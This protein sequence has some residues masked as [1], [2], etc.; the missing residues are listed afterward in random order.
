MDIEKEQ[1]AIARLKAFEPKEE[2]YYLCY[3]GGKDSD[4]IRI[5]AGLAGVRHEVHHNLTTV[6]APETVGYVKSFDYVMIDKAYYADGTHKTMWNLIQKK[7]LPPTRLM[8]YCCEQL[9]EHGGEG[10]MKITGVRWAES[11]SRKENGGFVK[12]IG[13]PKTTQK[14]LTENNV[15]FLLTARGGVVL[16]H[17][18]AET[19]R[20]VEYCYRTVSTM[21]NPIIDW[22]DDDV[23]EFLHHYG[24]ESNPL[25]QCGYK[26]IGCVGCPMASTTK[27]RYDFERHPAYKKNYIKAF[28]RM[29]EARKEAG[30]ETEWKSGY[31]VFKWWMGKDINQLSFFDDEL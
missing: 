26:R 18:N 5:L 22:S 4:C 29:L 24:C 12:M 19:R 13:K 2:P 30:L 28:D 9:K 6:D 14:Y 3:S 31:E 1:K 27:R 17:D 21:V 23:W 7:K 10:R 15:D 16:N 11:R 25:Y 20:A 8:R